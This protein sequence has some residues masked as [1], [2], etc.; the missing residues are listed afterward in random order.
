MYFNKIQ[1]AVWKCHWHHFPRQSSSDSDIKY[2]RTAHSAAQYFPRDD[3]SSVGWSVGPIPRIGPSRVLC[4]WSSP[5]LLSVM[6]LNLRLFW[7][8]SLPPGV[9]DAW[10]PILLLVQA[11]QKTDRFDSFGPK[12]FVWFPPNPS[13][14]GVVIEFGP[15]AWRMDA[16]RSWLWISNATQVWFYYCGNASDFGRWRRRTEPRRWQMLLFRISDSCWKRGLV[17]HLVADCWWWVVF[18]YCDADVILRF[19]T[20]SMTV[21]GRRNSKS[22]FKCDWLCFRSRSRCWLWM[23]NVGIF[24]RIFQCM[25]FV[26]MKDRCSQRCFN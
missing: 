17:N 13:C 26:G 6:V 3:M 1:N 5:A 8:S 25:V 2:D 15:T 21:D 22:R 24:R 11:K 10:S 18:C 4:Q 20:I 12:I 23:S 9:I 14:C 7:V 19:T 16:I